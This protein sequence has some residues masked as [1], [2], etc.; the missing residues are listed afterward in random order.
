M[1]ETF[2]IMNPREPHY[3]WSL[4]FPT[5]D[6][7]QTGNRMLEL[8]PKP[9]PETDVQSPDRMH[10]TLYYNPEPGP[11]YD[12]QEMFDKL[13]SQRVTLRTLY[14]D[15]A[16][17]AACTVIL[18]EPAERLLAGWSPNPHVSLMKPKSDDWKNMANWLNNIEGD[19]HWEPRGGGWDYNSQLQWWRQMLNL[20]LT[21]TSRTHLSETRA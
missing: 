17:H 18:P 5:P 15:E 1:A 21:I 16:G 7:T 14:H 12:Y 11:D 6:P 19:S 3:W 13:G 4:D 8:L 20:T 9:P 2:V 10:I